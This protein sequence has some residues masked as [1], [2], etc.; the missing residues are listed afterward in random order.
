MAAPPGLEV[1]M[2]SLTSY[3]NGKEI[4]PVVDERYDPAPVGQPPTATLPATKSLGGFKG[5]DVLTVASIE[6]DLGTSFITWTKTTSL[7][8]LSASSPT[9][10]TALPP[11]PKPSLSPAQLTPPAETPSPKP[12]ASPKSS[13]PPRSLIQPRAT[14]PPAESSPP[15]RTGPSPSAKF[16]PREGP[17]THPRQAPSQPEQPGVPRQGKQRPGESPSAS[18]DEDDD[19]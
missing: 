11:S 6:K 8:S 14:T 18:P 9:P 13:T 10:V 12:E 3:L 5:G 1:T 4:K 2:S 7:P 19:E 16:A 15:P 17:Q